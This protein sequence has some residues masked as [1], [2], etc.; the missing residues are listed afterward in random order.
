MF[1]NFRGPQARL[2][3]IAKTCSWVRPPQYLREMSFDSFDNGPPTYKET[4][5]EAI[6]PPGEIYTI[7]EPEENNHKSS[8]QEQ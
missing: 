1:I 4:H 5:P 6:K 3:V 7:P 2:T 8:V